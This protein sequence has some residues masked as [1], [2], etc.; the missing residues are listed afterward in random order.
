MIFRYA[1]SQRNPSNPFK[2]NEF[3]NR[4]KFDQIH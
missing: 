2:M 4:V 3:Q 1:K